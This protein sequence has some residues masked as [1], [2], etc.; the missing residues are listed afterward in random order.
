[1]P[2]VRRARPDELTDHAEHDYLVLYPSGQR[3]TLRGVLSGLGLDGGAAH[4]GIRAGAR[5]V[6]LDPRAVIVRD[7]LIIRDPRSH[8]PSDPAMRTWLREH[9]EW[10]D[11]AT[12]AVS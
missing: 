1:M 5:L 9:P 3:F 2:S 4:I 10:P 7:G 12:E 6:L 8:P 11:V